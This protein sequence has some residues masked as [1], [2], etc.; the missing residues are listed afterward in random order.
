MK[1]FMVLAALLMVF[2]MNAKAETI[3]RSDEGDLTINV[4]ANIIESFKVTITNDDIQ[5][6]GPAPVADGLLDL[7]GGM[8]GF[9]GLK[10]VE[11]GLCQDDQ[12]ASPAYVDTARTL[13]AVQNNGNASNSNLKF[14]VDLAVKVELSGPGSVDLAASFAGTNGDEAFQNETILFASNNSGS[15]TGLADQAEDT[16]HFYGEAA[17]SGGPSY[18]D[19]IVVSVTKN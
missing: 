7:N 9:D 4:F 1:K 14:D 15:V 13:C 10:S 5:L 8:A 11:S 2:G 16:L 17:F 19:T 18:D 12:G 3:E 6:A